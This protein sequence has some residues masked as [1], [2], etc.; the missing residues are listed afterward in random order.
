MG[1]KRSWIED[2]S[3]EGAKFE[4]TARVA[5]TVVSLE[6]E[7]MVVNF[8]QCW[9]TKVADEGTEKTVAAVEEIYQRWAC[10]LKTF[11]SHGVRPA[12]ISMWCF[13]LVTW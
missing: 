10:L 13:C 6:A 8:G 12:T 3:E 11:K 9:G 1:E 5:S 2:W 4:M 7:D